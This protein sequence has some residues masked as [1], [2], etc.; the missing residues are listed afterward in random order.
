VTW[1]LSDGFEE[2]WKRIRAGGCPVKVKS[3]EKKCV[4]DGNN[5]EKKLSKKSL[6]V[7]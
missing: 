1:P 6:E 3:G 7:V 2:G 5:S 4:E